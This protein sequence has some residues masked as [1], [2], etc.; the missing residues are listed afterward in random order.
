MAKKHVS[1]FKKYFHFFAI[2][3]AGALYFGVKSLIQ[4]AQIAEIRVGAETSATVSCIP[5]PACLD[6]NP[7]CMIKMPEGTV[8]CS[9]LPSSIP[10]ASCRPRPAC[11]DASPQCRM[12]ETS[13]MCPRSPVPSPTIFYDPRPTPT[14]VPQ[15][16]YYQQIQCVRAPC[17][18]VLICAS[19]SPTL[20]PKP[21]PTPTPLPRNCYTFFGR[22]WCR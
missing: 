17:N 12:K 16:C 4:T 14:P 18:P 3:F 9:P 2:V 7:A 22:K 10:L 20:K 13:D 19:P 5:R 15:G 6:A 1:S 11:L 21:T 8:L